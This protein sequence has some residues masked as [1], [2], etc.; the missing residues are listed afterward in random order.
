MTRKI[1]TQTAKFLALP[2]VTLLVAAGGCGS[3][4]P[5]TPPSQ[6]PGWTLA[7]IQEAVTAAKESKT[8]PKTEAQSRCEAAWL[9]GTYT[10]SQIPVLSPAQVA[11]IRTECGVK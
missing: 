8:H 6:K 5:S 11:A 7:M 2:M 9:V 4:Q 10:P 3:A 1:N